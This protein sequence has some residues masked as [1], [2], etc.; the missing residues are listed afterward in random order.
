MIN[1]AFCVRFAHTNSSNLQSDKSPPQQNYASHESLWM[2]RGSP[3][4]FF[5]MRTIS[6]GIW[7]FCAN[8][9]RILRSRYMWV[10]TSE[11][12]VQ[13]VKCAAIFR[14][15]SNSS[16][17]SR[18]IARNLL[19]KFGCS[20][21]SL[22]VSGS[23]R[24]PVIYLLQCARVFL[25]F[26]QVENWIR[27][28]S[29]TNIICRQDVCECACIPSV[30]DVRLKVNHQFNRSSQRTKNILSDRKRIF[31]RST[32]DANTRKAERI[33]QPIF[34][35]AGTNSCHWKFKRQTK[36]RSKDNY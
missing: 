1:W 15:G 8:E 7:W 5:A 28:Q 12:L 11:I 29:T 16:R 2:G 30:W 25:I 31:S 10:S 6:Y 24:K 36:S 3:S 13:S 20:T 26:K 22:D 18:E 19:W 17:E 35:G 4:F 27:G 33:L 32:E 23:D 34:I 21:F 14:T 9:L